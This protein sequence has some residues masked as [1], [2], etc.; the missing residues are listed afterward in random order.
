VETRLS[1]ASHEPLIGALSHPNGWWRDTA[2]QLLVQRAVRAASAK[3]AVTPALIRLT[4][5]AKDWRAR[6]H[7]LWTLDGID[8][9]EPDLVTKALEDT[10]RDVRAAAVR[11]AE[12]W[13]GGAEH[14]I[15]TAVRKRLDDPDWIVRRQVAASLGVLPPGA[16]E[17]SLALVLERYGDDPITL[18]AALS[19]LRG[20]EGV[21]L[22]GLIGSGR[23]QTPQ[24]DATIAMLSAMLVRS[25]Q[26]AAVQRILSAAADSSRASWQRSAVLQG[27]EIAL[28]GRPTPGSMPPRARGNAN[29]APAPCPTCPGGRAGPGGAYAFPDAHAATAAASA[30]G[31]G[32]G[33]RSMLRLNREPSQLTALAARNDDFGSRIS[34]LLARVTWPGKP[35]DENAVPPLTDEEQRRFEAGRDV[36]RSICQACHQ[37]DGRGQE[38]LAPT[39]I[40]SAF[41]LAPAEVPVRILLNGKEGPV[42]LMPPIGSTFTDDQ[43]AAVLTYVRREWGQTGTPVAPETV[44]AVRRLTAGRTRPWTDE[45]LQALVK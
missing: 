6:L 25:G 45:E 28:L 26:E 42:G 10:S 16:R 1:N 23:S 12:R 35:G 29:R 36:Y 33:G 4:I 17:S 19:G 40:D 11:V 34:S 27:A 8:A 43:V 14:P 7:A 32:R 37:P 31:S 38:R 44:T 41:A 2:Q 9:I 5:E 20:S 21:V 39:L 22:E 13:L 3:A 30:S 15:S 18:D 24:L